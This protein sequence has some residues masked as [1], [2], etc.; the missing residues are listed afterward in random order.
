MDSRPTLPRPTRSTGV[1]AR[2]EG[3][4]LQ[5]YNNEQS[6]TRAIFKYKPVIRLYKLEIP[7]LFGVLCRDE[8]TVLS[9]EDPMLFDE[10]L[11]ELLQE[12]GPLVWP[13]PNGVN[14]G[15]LREAQAGTPYG[16]D[17]VYPRDAAM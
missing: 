4:G 11:D 12:Y 6:A 1:H 8:G 14:R 13:V 15:H 3:L 16:A 10:D 2:L 9:R 17:L 7:A 5:T